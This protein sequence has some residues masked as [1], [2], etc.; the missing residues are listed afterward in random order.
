[1]TATLRLSLLILMAA[2]AL[3][4]CKS[5]PAESDDSMVGPAMTPGIA[6]PAQPVALAS[7]MA[8]DQSDLPHGGIWLIT[9]E[10]ELAACGSQTL[11]D[12]K[13]NLSKQDLVVVGLGPQQSAGYWVRITAI[14][15]VG[16]TLYVQGCANAPAADSPTAMVTTSPYCAALIA[17]TGSNVVCNDI[18]SVT[19]KNPPTE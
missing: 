15:K 11:K 14:Q 19:G 3:G 5:A 10:K 6:E 8:A 13:V 9:S 12:L 2:L 17:K 1:M 4:G 7:T 18:T 16:D